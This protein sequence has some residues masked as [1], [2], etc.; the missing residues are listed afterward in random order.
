MFFLRKMRIRLIISPVLL[1]GCFVAAQDRITLTTP[2]QQEQLPPEEKHLRTGIIILAQLCKTMSE[3]NDPQSAQAAVPIIVRLS[4]E[5]HL[6]GQG[7]AQLPQRNETLMSTYERR[8]LP[9]IEK[10]NSHLRVQGER[11]AASSYY[12]SQDLPTALM[13]LYSSVQQ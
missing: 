2:L 11:L 9:I 5:L 3:V 1:L 4:R 7:I 8:Y 6:W 13:A 10:L 12:G